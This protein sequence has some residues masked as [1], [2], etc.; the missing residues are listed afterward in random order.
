MRE[1]DKSFFFFFFLVACSRRC[2]FSIARRGGREAGLRGAER[3]AAAPKAFTELPA[4]CWLSAFRSN[5]IP[6]YSV[7]KNMFIIEQKN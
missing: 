7:A 2:Q 1:N 3:S 6:G 5:G 4:C